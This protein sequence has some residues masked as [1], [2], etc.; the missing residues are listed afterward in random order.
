MTGH[1]LVE[2]DA[3][4]ASRLTGSKIWATGQT[5][6]AAGMSAAHNARTGPNVSFLTIS[7]RSVGPGDAMQRG[8]DF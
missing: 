5:Y 2:G 8:R 3:S 1:V 6:I 7:P 4:G